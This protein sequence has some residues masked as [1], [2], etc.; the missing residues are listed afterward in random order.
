MT[1]L[2]TQDAIG[3]LAYR[4]PPDG[5][6]A[7]R[8]RWCSRHRTTGSAEGGGA[9]ALLGA[10]E[11][12]IDADRIT[13]RPLTEAIAQGPPPGSA[14]R[15][16]DYPTGAGRREIPGD[17]VDAIRSSAEDVAD[18]RSIMIDGA[19]VGRTPDEVIG[20]LRRGLVR[21]ASAELRALPDVAHATADLATNRIRDIRGA[22]RVLEPPSPYSLGTSDA[23]LPLTVVNGLPVSVHV[24]SSSPARP[25]SRWRRWPRWRSRLSGRRQVSVNAKVTRSGQFTVDASVLSP[26]SGLLGSP[27]RLLVRST[28]Y[29]TITLWLTASAGVLLVLLVGRRVLRK[30]RGEPGRHSEAVPHGPPD[31]IPLDP[32]RTSPISRSGPSHP[33]NRSSPDRAGPSLPPRPASPSH[34]NPSS[35]GRTPV[36]H[37][38]LRGDPF[39]GVPSR[40]ARPVPSGAPVNG[41]PRPAVRPL[42]DDSP[43]VPTD[44]MFP[45][46]HPPEPP[47]DPRTPAPRR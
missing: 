27:S 32:S 47:L 23:P 17:V 45:V 16:A 42:P 26:G 15:A 12:L 7:R 1:P 14:T 9:R 30:I 41:S 37:P 18:L 21:P 33:S 39:P 34:P 5:R 19:G 28:A 36:H 4:A 10:A 8:S 3:T 40:P 20:P 43:E 2:S 6:A 13:P 29:G 35:L 11:Q 25:A 22:V 44:R 46:R 38:N 31:P 24:G